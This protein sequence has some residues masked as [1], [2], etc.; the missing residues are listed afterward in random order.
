MFFTVA[1]IE[2]RGPEIMWSLPYKAE[3]FSWSLI[4]YNSNKDMLIDNSA[5]LYNRVYILYYITQNYLVAIFLN[6]R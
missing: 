4:S 3:F 6:N 5:Y 1:H 2:E